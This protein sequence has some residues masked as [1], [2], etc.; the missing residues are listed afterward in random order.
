MKNKSV[1]VIRLSS[2]GDIIRAV[3][4]LKSIKENCRRL[5]FLTEDRFEETARLFPYFDRLI[6][7]PR[8]RLSYKSLRQFF[9]ELREEQFDF[10]LDIHGI[11]KSALIS[12]I[13]R[14][15]K[16]AG[17]PRN[18]S[19]EFSYIFY[20]DK[21]ACGDEEIISR[22]ERYNNALRYLGIE[23]LR[24][25]DF[26]APSIS[27]EAKIFAENFLKKNNLQ[28]NRYAFLFIGASKKQKFKR[29]PLFRFLRL[30]EILEK[31]MN[32]KS[33]F[34]YGPDEK[35]L[36]VE[37]D[38]TTLDPCDLPKTTAVILN[39]ALFV[40]ADTGL[41]HLSALSGV[42]TVAVIGATNPVINKP[43]GNLSCVAFKEG[44]T[45]GCDGENCPHENCMGKITEKDIFE[46]AKQLLE[47]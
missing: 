43:Y 32:L 23:P 39:S 33:V 15:L 22:Y 45:K 40:G 8:K 5:V 26:F 19:K 25:T 9:S 20:K 3:P 28:K 36:V 27:E 34:A 13:S 12:R 29:W 47:R 6:L 31:E 11:F 21:F 16:I 30:A 4:S 1:L 24:Q 35:D 46:K 44:I 2:M 18:F 42:K 7:F 41:M 14:S 17:Y 37:T 10:T 38:F